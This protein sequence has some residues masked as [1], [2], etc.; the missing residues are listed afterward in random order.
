MLASSALQRVSL[1]C[2]RQSKC[3]YTTV[4]AIKMAG[5][6]QDGTLPPPP[7]WEARRSAPSAWHQFEAVLHKNW[8]LRLKGGCAAAACRHWARLLSLQGRVLALQ[9]T[10]AGHPCSRMWTYMRLGVDLRHGPP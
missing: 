7:P 6:S 4:A 5:S 8:L 9:G 2:D 10:Q 1:H 3:R